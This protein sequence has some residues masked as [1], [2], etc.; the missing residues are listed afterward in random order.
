MESVRLLTAMI[1]PYDEN[2]EI[3]YEK[4]GE[5]ANYLAS[6]GSDGVIVSGTTGESPVLT[7]EE[8]LQLLETV[9]KAAGDK[10]QVWSGTGSNNTKETIKLSLEAEKLGADGIMLVT[11]YYNKP[12]QEGLYQHFKAIASKLS[13]PVMLYNVPGR[14]SSNLLPETVAKLVEIDN[15]VAVKEASGN[16]DQVSLLKSLIADRAM[17]YSGDDSLTLP[18]MALG[19]QGVVSIASHIIGNEIKEMISL[20]AA[21]EVNKAT[22]MHIKLFPIFRG[23]FIASNPV[24]LKESLNLLGKEV[25]N[26]R[27]PLT[28]ASDEEREFIKNLL[29]EHNLL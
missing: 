3:N 26:L 11:P 28:S 29:K 18:I 1:T 6:N 15:I 19:G 14:T 17:I 27:L 25:G 9:K 20:F 8:K 7:G 21:A 23:L 2:L 12:S 22:E 16:M 24:P 10:M 4:A 5:I 13:L